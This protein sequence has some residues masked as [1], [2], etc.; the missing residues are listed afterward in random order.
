M[1]NPETVK[2]LH[3]LVRAM[4]NNPEDIAELEIYGDFPGH[5]A[6]VITD[7]VIETFRAA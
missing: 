5:I 6:D 1:L 2:A 3:D 7:H 4:A